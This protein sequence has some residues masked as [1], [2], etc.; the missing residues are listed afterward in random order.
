MATVFTFHLSGM[1]ALRATLMAM[2]QPPRQRI[3]K[4]C[5][6]RDDVTGCLSPIDRPEADHEL[7]R[8]MGELA[9]D[10]NDRAAPGRNRNL[11]RVACETT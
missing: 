7:A 11:Y 1:T 6:E 10:R 3:V 9:G 2:A 4:L 8:G 5:A